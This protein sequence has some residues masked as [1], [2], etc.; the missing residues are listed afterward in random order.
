[1][2]TKKPRKGRRI[3]ST[4]WNPVALAVGARNFRTEFHRLKVKAD[5]LCIV[6]DNVP[7]ICA[8]AGRLLFVTLRALDLQELQIEETDAIDTLAIMGCALGDALEADRI[9]QLQ[10][11]ALMAGMDH[12]VALTEV[13]SLESLGAAWWQLEQALATGNLGTDAL[14]DMLAQVQRRPAGRAG[15]PANTTTPNHPSPHAA[16]FVISGAP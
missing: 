16:G 14:N 9:D 8:S 5:Q 4:T 10:R 15:P 3:A 1:M 13:L 6:S 2:Q 11:T 12:L 7:D